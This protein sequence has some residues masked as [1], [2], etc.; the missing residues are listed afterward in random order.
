M[1]WIADRMRSAKAEANSPR[2]RI[3]GEAIQRPRRRDARR[4]EPS[5]PSDRQGGMDG[6]QSQLSLVVCVVTTEVRLANGLGTPLL[7]CRICEVHG[8]EL[9]D[10][11][12]N[13]PT[14]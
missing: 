8:G 3:D 1:P 5:A 11:N 7:P 6:R 2:V 14:L 10:A 9:P 4:L 13:A 12:L